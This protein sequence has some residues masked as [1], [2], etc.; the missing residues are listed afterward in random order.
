[1]TF[2]S[3]F[4]PAL[5]ALLSWAVIMEIFQ[6]AMH[7]WAD[8]KRAQKIAELQ[9]RWNEL[10]EKGEMPPMDMLANFLP[11]DMNQYAPPH[12]PL[13]TTSGE[14]DQEPHGQYL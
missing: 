8:K 11:A 3:I 5:A 12:P 10:K 13:L 14:A 7:Y 9:E 6:F 1:M 2:W 4:W